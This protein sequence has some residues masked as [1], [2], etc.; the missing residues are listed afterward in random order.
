MDNKVQ[1]SLDRKLLEHDFEILREMIAISELSENDKLVYNDDETRF[2]VK[3]RWSSGNKCYYSVGLR[4]ILYDHEADAREAYLNA[5]LEGM[6]LHRKGIYDETGVDPGDNL[7]AAL[8]IGEHGAEFRDFW[9]RT[10][11]F[12][13]TDEKRSECLEKARE[14][15]CEQ[16][17]HSCI[18]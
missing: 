12:V 17:I 1:E 9:K 6:Q 4:K 3:E 5:Q 7:A 10:H 8:W 14:E 18:Y 2:L 15:Y 11:T 13:M 16:Y